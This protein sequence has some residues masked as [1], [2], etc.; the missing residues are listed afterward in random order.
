MKIVTYEPKWCS[1]NEIFKITWFI[2]G[3]PTHDFSMMKHRNGQII[4]SQQKDAEL[5][6]VKKRGQVCC[7]YLMGLKSRGDAIKQ[8]SELQFVAPRNPTATLLSL[9]EFLANLKSTK[10]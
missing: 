9:V 3:K 1:K 8:L 4:A 5:I 2:D 6:E 7:D 10:S